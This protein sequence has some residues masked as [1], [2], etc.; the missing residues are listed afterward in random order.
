[1]TCHVDGEGRLGPRAELLLWSS[2]HIQPF[3][4]SSPENRHV[5]RQR[6]KKK[7]TKKKK[8]KEEEEEKLLFYFWLFYFLLHCFWLFDHMLFYFTT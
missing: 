1:V 6:K 8:K 4:K 5:D 3:G 7:K 2:T